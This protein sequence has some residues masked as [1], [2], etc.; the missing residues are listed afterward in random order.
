MIAKK[1]P[2]SNSAIDD[3]AGADKKQKG[4]SQH[5]SSSRSR[6]W[7][8]VASLLALGTIVARSSRPSEDYAVCSAD[9]KIY[10]V[11]AT[12][13]NA[14]CIVVRDTIITDVGDLGVFHFPLN[15]SFI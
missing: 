8:L 3:N 13:P 12:H 10:T 15:A 6:S 9:R 5:P 2:K 4:A 14:Q 11:D 1:H 7:A